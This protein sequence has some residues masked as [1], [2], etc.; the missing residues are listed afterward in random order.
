MGQEF[1]LGCGGLHRIGNSEV[2][3]EEG[4][5]LGDSMGSLMIDGA[6]QAIHQQRL[7]T[8]YPFS[9]KSATG[10]T[11]SEWQF[12]GS[13]RPPLNVLKVQKPKAGRS[14]AGESRVAGG[15]ALEEK[16]RDVHPGLVAPLGAR[17][18]VGAL[19]GRPRSGCVRA[20]SAVLRGA[21]SGGHAVN[22]T[23]S[24]SG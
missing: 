8:L 3:R 9:A 2:K 14:D 6:Y 11:V 22:P 17:L 16:R 24:A 5:I 20:R 15:R 18:G 1:K 12:T 23:A 13:L 19:G 7:Q 4:L 21:E 10:N